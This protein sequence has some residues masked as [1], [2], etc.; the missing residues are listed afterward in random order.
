[1]FVSMRYK[2]TP[3]YL[4]LS[5][6]LWMICL[7]PPPTLSMEAMPMHMHLP[8]HMPLSLPVSVS[9][10]VPV[11][12]SVSVSVSVPAVQ[13]ERPVIESDENPRR[14]RA[15]AN[16]VC[17]PSTYSSDGKQPCSPCALGMCVIS[18]YPLRKK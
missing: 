11:P 2:P 12:V 8:V 5:L 1:M 13:I 16:E 4:Y 15:N 7:L 3:L 6:L 14:F 9:V 10:P 18:F 17:P